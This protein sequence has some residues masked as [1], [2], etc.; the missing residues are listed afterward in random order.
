MMKTRIICLM[1]M[2]G[3]LAGC[4]KGTTDTQ[5]GAL[6]T[7]TVTFNLYSNTPTKIS[8]EPSGEE[9]IHDI[10]VFIYDAHGKYAACAKGSG[11]SVDVDLYDGS[12]TAVAL[13]NAPSVES[14]QSHDLTT[15]ERTRYRLEDNSEGKLLMY[16]SEAFEVSGESAGVSINVKR[17]VAR[18]SINKITNSIKDPLYQTKEFKVLRIFVSNVSASS[19]IKGTEP[20]SEWYNKNGVWG[21]ESPNVKAMLEDTSLEQTITLEGSYNGSHH[22]YVYPNST[23]TDSYDEIWSERYTRLIVEASIGGETCYYNIPF[24]GIESNHTYTV[25]NLKITKKGADN[26][27]DKCESE[28]FEVSVTV[29]D[30]EEGSTSEKVI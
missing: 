11:A 14:G 22:Y 7:H 25:T 10:Q 24:G 20:V 6:G 17:S 4:Q 16:G 26:P 9:S 29:S 21:D 12:Y 5:N 23:P 8:G 13:V 30:W 27:W 2:T 28:T 19:D 3:A 15:L 18:I 1:L